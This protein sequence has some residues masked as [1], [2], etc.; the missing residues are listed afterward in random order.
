MSV[1]MKVKERKQIVYMVYVDECMYE[2][3]REKVDCV[4]GVVDECVYECERVCRLCTWCMQMS[5]CMKVKERKQIVYMVYVSE[6]KATMKIYSTYNC[7]I[8]C[9]TF[10]KSTCYYPNKRDEKSVIQQNLT[11]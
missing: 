11:P 8:N 2:S 9:D 5:V 1:C 6:C 7:I 10:I 3:E 4:H